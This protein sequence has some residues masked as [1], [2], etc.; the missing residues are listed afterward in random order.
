MKEQVLYGTKRGQPD[1]MEDI[2]STKPENFKRATTWAKENGY[3]RLRVAAIDLSIK[4]DFTG[5]VSK[6]VFKQR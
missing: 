2:I 5:I 6:K 3:D 4:P 1:Y